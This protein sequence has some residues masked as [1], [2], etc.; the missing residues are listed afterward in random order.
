M[1]LAACILLCL[2]GIGI[3]WDLTRVWVLSRSDPDYHSF[4]AVSEGMNCETVALSSWS[5]NFGAPNSVWA[6]AGYAFAIVLAGIAASRRRDSLGF[7]LLVALGVGFAIVSVALLVVMQAMIGSLCILC[8]ALDLINASLL[9]FAI[10]AAR[11]VHTG[12]FATVTS[13]L[14]ALVRRPAFGAL[15][16]AA[17]L[18]LLGTSWAAGHRVMVATGLPERGLGAPVSPGMPSAAEP[19]C[20]VAE[21]GDPASGPSMGVTPDGHPWIGATNPILEVQEFTD[22]QCPHCRRAHMMVR[23]LLSTAGSRVRVYHRHLPLDQACNPAIQSP[24]H[25]RA[26]ELSRVALCSGRQGRFWEMND[27]LFQQADEIREKD[28]SATDIAGRLELDLDAFRCCLDEA[29]TKEALAVD[30][31]EANALGIKGTPAFVV[32]GQVNYGKIPSAALE[33][34]GIVAP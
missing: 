34:A 1:A 23:K 21:T 7:G 19:V 13:D 14:A 25:K 32:N 30:V 2:V 28:L 3:S 33:A 24:F 4:C 29:S 22:Y 16:V 20:G 27:F 8:L 26:C 15:V 11:A 18:G 31:A 10:V 6:M 17:G 5:T 9:A 12:A